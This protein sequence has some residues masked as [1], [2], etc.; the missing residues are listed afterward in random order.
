MTT[1]ERFARRRKAGRKADP[2]GSS[3]GAHS[4]REQAHDEQIARDLARV[5]GHFAHGLNFYKAV[6]GVFLCCFLEWSSDYFCWI[7]SGSAPQ[8]TGLV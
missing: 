3:G 1:Q 6:L 2:A 5:P 7:A 4:Q 8:R